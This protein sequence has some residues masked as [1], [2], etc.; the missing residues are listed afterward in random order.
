MGEVVI[1]RQLSILLLFL[2]TLNQ[3]LEN[4]H[5]SG[6]S[7][8]IFF[9]L[10]Q[11]IEFSSILWFTKLYFSQETQVKML[12]KQKCKSL[13]DLFMFLKQPNITILF[14]FFLFC[15][16]F[17]LVHCRQ[18]YRFFPLYL[19]VP[20]ADLEILWLQSNCFYKE[21]K[22]MFACRGYE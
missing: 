6:E 12:L 20:K 7:L 15:R 21:L 9:S 17:L 22:T 18:H 10:L 14:S 5:C 13:T 11:F 4:N 2:Q 16:Q 1:K 8:M 3:E 19:L